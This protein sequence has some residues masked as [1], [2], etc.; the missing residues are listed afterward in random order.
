L[1]VDQDEHQSTISPFDSN[2]PNY[3]WINGNID[4]MEWKSADTPRALLLSA[5]H[6]HGTKEICKHTIE[7]AKEKGSPVNGSVLYFFSSCAPQSQ[8]STFLIHTLLHQVACSSDGK[9]NSIGTAF[10]GSLVG[11]HF[12][13]TKGLQHQQGFQVDDP[14]S[15]TVQRLLEAPHSDLVEALAEAIKESGIQELS[16]IV[17]GLQENIVCLLFEVISRAMPKS[18][19]LLT[20]QDK[21]GQPPH[22]MRYIE[23]DKERQGLHV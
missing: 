19:V 3:S 7:L 16:I 13:R 2:D 17:D 23:Y 1:V 4:Y 10:L 8:S 6:S 20:S 15:N 14:L 11:A 9:A 5:P 21:F 18:E 22:G 12:E